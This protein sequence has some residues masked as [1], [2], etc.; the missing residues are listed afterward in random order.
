MG[1]LLQSVLNGGESDSGADNNGDDLGALF[2]GVGMELLVGDGNDKGEENGVSDGADGRGAVIS[3]FK[4]AIVRG[5]TMP[6]PVV[7]ALPEFTILY[8]T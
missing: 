5:P 7:I 1:A 4:T 8:V 2:E 6:K 3:I